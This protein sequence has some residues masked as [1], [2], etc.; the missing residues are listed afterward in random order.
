M[1]SLLRSREGSV[2]LSATVSGRTSGSSTLPIGALSAARLASGSIVWAAGPA[3]RHD[4]CAEVGVS[5]VPGTPRSSA[6]CASGSITSAGICIAGSAAAGRHGAVDAA[7]AAGRHGAVE[8]AAAPGRH[9]A[10]DA[11]AAAGRHGAVEA[12]AAASRQ[13]AVEAAAA[14]GTL[15][16]AHPGSLAPPG[17][18][19]GSA[20]PR[21]FVSGGAG[22]KSWLRASVC[23][24]A[25]RITGVRVLQR[26]RR[27]GGGEPSAARLAAGTVLSVPALKRPTAR[28]AHWPVVS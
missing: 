25:A 22:W 11:A 3:S 18:L 1:A 7:S 24:G 2:A 15:R 16:D 20:G 6:C 17:S 10:V 14:A 12:T 28:T 23:A 19:L 13:C 27:R 21:A 4:A 26:V 5:T 9:G 8:A